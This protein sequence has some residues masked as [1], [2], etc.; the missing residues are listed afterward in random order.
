MEKF[1]KNLYFLTINAGS[2][3]VKF[4]IFSLTEPLNQIVKGKIERI[5]LANAH[6]SIHTLSTNKKDEKEVTVK[7]TNEALTLFFSWLSKTPFQEIKAVGHRVVHG[8]GKYHLPTKIT[9]E[10]LES[11]SSLSIFDPEHMPRE[12]EFMKALF[13]KWPHILHVACF[14]TAFHHDMPKISQMFSLPRHLEKQ[15][16]RRYGFHGLSYDFLFSE[17]KKELTSPLLDKKIILAHL[18]NGA[19]LCAIKNGKSFDTTMGL[20]PTSGIAMSTRSGDLDPGLMMFLKK[21]T[22][23][24]IDEF[25][26]MI[27]KKSGLLGISETSQDMQDLLNLQEKDFRAKEAIDYFCMQ[28]KK[29]IGAYSAS[30]GGI[31]IL[32]F[33]GGIGEKAPSIRKAICENL[34]FLNIEIDNEKN[35]NNEKVLSIKNSKVKIFQL[36]T[37]EEMI[38]AKSM[39]S[40]YEKRE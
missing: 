6:F 30:L 20:T 36:E 2:S 29:T 19:S 34:Q 38:I 11:L 8:G 26:E 22:G 31:D 17:L 3:S 10:L 28:V 27:N 1:T 9:K 5:G 23:M 21:T 32:V 12:L 4:S 25:N 37:N 24:E 35:E 40:L 33:S 14:D 39:L 13:Q 15:G 18:G 7:D 16:V